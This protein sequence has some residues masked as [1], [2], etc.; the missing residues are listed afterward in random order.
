MFTKAVIESIDIS[1]RSKRCKVTALITG[2]LERIRTA[3]ELTISRIP[4]NLQYGDV[5][6]NTENSAECIGGAIDSL[7][8]A[9]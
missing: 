2:L 3:D 4:E 9:Y 8:D 1:T 7:M 6:N 5:Y